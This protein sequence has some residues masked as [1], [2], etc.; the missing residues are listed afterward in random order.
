MIRPAQSIADGWP[1]TAWL[2]HRCLDERIHGAV[3]SGATD[4]AAGSNDA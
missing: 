2:A 4:A 3:K 1:V